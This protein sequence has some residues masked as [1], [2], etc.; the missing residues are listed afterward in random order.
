MKTGNK[1]LFIAL[2]ASLPF[3]ASAYD[4]EQ[5]AHVLETVTGEMDREFFVTRP[6]KVEAPAV[7]EMLVKKQPVTLLDIRTPEEQAVIALNH[8]SAIAIPMNELFKKENLDRLPQDGRIVVVCH[9]G[10]RA[11]GTT[12]LLKSVG[13]KDVVYLNGG[14][15]SLVTNL[16]PKTAP[17]E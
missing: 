2:F 13:F 4:A 9:S 6:C 17:T 10:N 3:A 12:A 15:I 5:A 1:M 7:L 14:M 16:T 8:T 11:A